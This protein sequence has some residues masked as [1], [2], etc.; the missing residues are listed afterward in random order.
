MAKKF[1]YT[2]QLD[3]KMKALIKSN[4]R[5]I[6]DNIKQGV[7]S[8]GG[9]KMSLV[10]VRK[11]LKLGNK[12]D[13]NK[14]AK[15][16]KTF[17]NS[18]NNK[19]IDKLRK[20]YNTKITKTNKLDPLN[21]EFQPSKMSKKDMKKQ[22]DSSTRKDINVM[23]REMGNYLKTGGEKI[24]DSGRGAKTT[25]STLHNFKVRKNALNKAKKIKYDLANI[26]ATNKG[27]VGTTKSNV[28]R[29]I[30]SKFEG[31]SQQGW[32]MLV[33]RI[34]NQSRENFQF[35][36]AEKYKVDYLKAI[37]R[38]LGHNGHALYDYIQKQDPQFLLDH[39]YDDQVVQIQFTSDDLPSADI[40]EAS[41]ERWKKIKSDIAE[42][43]LEA[44]IDK[45]MKA[46]YGE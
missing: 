14:M 25:K 46:Q 30:N 34:N 23:K 6:S 32:D 38:N 16:I 4:N 36:K 37:Q 28:L 29:Q 2:E 17:V 31:N 27:I 12:S 22:V 5:R 20:Q 33:A 10:T 11:Q 41:L 44:E 19:E 26:D 39:Y 35:I 1:I 3:N 45:E 7:S 43:E 40:A 42:K 8:G 18:E 13:Y 15:G 24:V 21:A 9:S